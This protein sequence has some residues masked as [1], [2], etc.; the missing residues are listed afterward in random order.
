[1]Y[2]ID[3]KDRKIL[4]QLDLNCRQSNTQIGKNVGLKKDVVSYRIKRLQEA[5]IIKNFYTE[6]NTFKLGYNVFRIYINFQYVSSSIKEEIIRYFINYQNSWVIA[7]E[8][9]EIDLNIVIWVKDIYEF[10][11]FWDKTL[12]LYEDYFDK[13]SISIYI[14][15]I[16]YKK[17]Y[18]LSNEQEKSCREMFRMSCGGLPVEVDEVDYQLLNE[19]TIN[20]RIPLI[21]IAEKLDCSS[22]SVSYRLKNLIKLGVIR[23]FRV[24]IDLSKL[25][26]QRFKVDIYLKDHKLKK[27]INDYLKDKSY[28]EFMNLTIGWADLEPEF[29]VKDF[30]ELMKILEEINSKFSGAI[31]KQSFFITEKIYLLRCLPKIYNTINKL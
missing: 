18:L 31:K 15:A 22:Q 30:D 11:S 6:I 5:G 14:Q 16:V 17:S 20:A 3:L 23:A 24:N 8:K 9:S 28:V 13:Y 1:M 19:L 2:K 21:D 10:Y 12:D 7:T 26:L 29:V 27:P 4:Y 25:N